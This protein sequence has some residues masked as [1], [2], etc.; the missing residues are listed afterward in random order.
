LI[1]AEL[2]EI[3]LSKQCELL[4]LSRSGYYYQPQ[5]ETE[6]NLQLMN[7]IDMQ[8]TKMPVY[9]IDKMTA[10]LRKSGYPVNPKRTRRLMRKMG[11]AAIY[12]KPNLSVSSVEHKKYPYLFKGFGD[13]ATG[14][15][16]ACRH[17]LHTDGT[18]F[19]VSRSDNGLA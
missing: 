7:L 14:S 13:S 4:G 12:P 17:N 18:G 11:L 15:S 1:K 9:G 16:L 3:P 10:W 2:I 6:L 8:Y 5:G 19:S